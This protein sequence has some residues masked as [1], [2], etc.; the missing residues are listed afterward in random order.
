MEILAQKIIEVQKK[1]D[2][3]EW[4]NFI[5]SFKGVQ[6]FCSLEEARELR[7]NGYAKSYTEGIKNRKGQKQS[8]KL[9]YQNSGKIMIVK[10]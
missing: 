6:D 1:N 8:K 4:N 2:S 9:S 5:D 10:L 7:K 3:E